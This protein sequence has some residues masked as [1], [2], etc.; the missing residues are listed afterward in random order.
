MAGGG[1][2]TMLHTILPTLLL[3]LLLHGVLGEI[4]TFSLP[5]PWSYTC[6]R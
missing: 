1:P 2:G 6:D 5:S 4:A 3:P